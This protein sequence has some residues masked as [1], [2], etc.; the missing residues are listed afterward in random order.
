MN[1]RNVLPPNTHHAAIDVPN[2]RFL[3]GAIKPYLDYRVALGDAHQ[4]ERQDLQSQRPTGVATVAA[5]DSSRRQVSASRPSAQ[6]NHERL[7]AVDVRCGTGADTPTDGS[8]L[9]RAHDRE[10]HEARPPDHRSV[11]Q[12]YSE[13]IR[14]LGGGK[15]RADV[16]M[17]AQHDAELTRDRVGLSAP[18]RLHKIH[19]VFGHHDQSSVSRRLGDRSSTEMASSRRH[20]YC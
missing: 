8:E 7:L 9:L 4:P 18:T 10:A 19:Q 1:V 17:G 3:L 20:A 2:S 16:R 11:A 6:A 14:Q 12:A 15:R 5:M 13:R